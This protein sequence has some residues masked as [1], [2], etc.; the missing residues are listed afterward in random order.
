M[1]NADEFMTLIDLIKNHGVIK[2]Y[3]TCVHISWDIPCTMCH[4]MCKDINLSWGTFLA[5]WLMTN[6]SFIVI[7]VLEGGAKKTVYTNQNPEQNGCHFANE[8][9][10]TL[11][12]QKSDYYVI[13]ICSQSRSNRQLVS[14]D[15]GNGLAPSRRQII[16]SI[17]DD[18]VYRRLYTSSGLRHTIK[19]I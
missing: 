11:S 10:I 15:S 9:L 5:R 19:S 17:N 6:Q 8:I 1:K 14:I 13:E 7:Y 3:R 16:S 18:P 12:W 4:F 2:T